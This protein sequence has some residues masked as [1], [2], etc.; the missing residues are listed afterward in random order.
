MSGA[1][2]DQAAFWTDGSGAKWVALQENLDA[3]FQP[4]LEGLLARARLQ[5]GQSVL[6]VGCG[7]GASTLQAARSVGPQGMV[8]G[9]DIS[10]T[11]LALARR[12]ASD[13]ANVKFEVADAEDHPFEPAEFDH[14]ISRFG[15]MFF[16]DPTRAFANM[17]T[18]LKPGA[19]VTLA[20]WGQMAANPWF[21]V[22]ARAAKEVLGAPPAVDPDEPG[23]FA[24][25]SPEKVTGILS[26][27]G[28]AEVEAETV[29][30][31]LTPSG[32]TEDAAWLAT[33]VGPAVRTI[34][35]FQG[36]DADAA[37]IANRIAREFDAFET[38]QGIRIPADLVFYH[39]RVPAA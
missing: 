31:Y 27:A 35:H 5:P 28:F 9:A 13:H 23:P 33:S 7:T 10:P 12:R 32:N 37:A 2:T 21:T 25:R 22:A 38:P 14:L 39:A 29:T 36:S 8:L 17:K 15:V 18:A 3:L 24:F 19:T 1:N 30:L 34:A 26:S 16:A 6:D 4:V 20:A 11:M